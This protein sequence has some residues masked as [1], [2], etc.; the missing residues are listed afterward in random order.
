MRRLFEL[1]TLWQYLP[2]ERRNPVELD[3]GLLSS[4]LAAGIRR[5]KGVK[6]LGVRLRNWQCP[7]GRPS[8]RNPRFDLQ[9]LWMSVLA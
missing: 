1:A 8:T 7:S 4:D 2:M 5:V 6:K 3:C 9:P